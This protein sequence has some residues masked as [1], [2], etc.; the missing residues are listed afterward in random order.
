MKFKNVQ[1][2]VNDIAHS[3]VYLE[4]HGENIVV[5]GHDNYLSAKQWR[6][7]AKVLRK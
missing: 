7:I 2:N 5:V 3:C 4:K 1:K 6:K